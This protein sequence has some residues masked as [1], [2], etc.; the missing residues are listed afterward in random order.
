MVGGGGKGFFQKVRFFN[1]LRHN[2]SEPYLTDDCIFT[3]FLNFL[4]N[5][6]RL[7]MEP[8]E[9]A[10]KSAT[11]NLHRICVSIF[12]ILQ[13]LRYM[14]PDFQISHIPD[15]SKCVVGPGDAWACLRIYRCISKTENVGQTISDPLYKL[16]V[17]TLPSIWQ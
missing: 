14:E 5:R 8:H 4:A 10:W 9:L 11:A 6:F 17:Y 7:G 3:V 16:I 1:Y 12:K 2:K 13:H 15:P